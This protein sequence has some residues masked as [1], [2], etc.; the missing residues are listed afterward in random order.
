M[1]DLLMMEGKMLQ[2]EQEAKGLRYRMEGLCSLV[3]GQLNVALSP[4]EEMDI[5]ESA[6]HMRDLE[7]AFVEYQI[8]DGRIARLKKEL[9]RG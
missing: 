4:V 2:L 6:Q 1:N 5:P 8:V 3:R 7:M 9:G